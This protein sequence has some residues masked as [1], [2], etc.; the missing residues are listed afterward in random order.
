[1]SNRLKT[2]AEP[3]ICELLASS[4]DTDWIKSLWKLRGVS[5]YI[6]TVV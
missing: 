3:A 2:V 6:V 4:I 5:G 1:M